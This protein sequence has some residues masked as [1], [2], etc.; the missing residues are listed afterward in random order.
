MTTLVS[1]RST[2]F[3]EWVVSARLLRS[4]FVLIDVGC[5]GGVHSRW[6]PLRPVM[7][8]YGF[9]PLVEEIEALTAR[10]TNP[11]IR[12]AAFAIGDV[13]GDR[14]IYVAVNR[15]QTSFYFDPNPADLK[16][17]RIEAGDATEGLRRVRVRTLDSLLAEG[18]VAKPDYV[19][20]DVEG[21][22]P[23]VIAGG[24]SALGSALMLESESGF[25]AS[26]D[27]P[28]CHFA[29]IS[30]PLHE[31]G[32]RFHSLG[33]WH[34]T[35]AC[36]AGGRLGADGDRLVPAP[37]GRIQGIDALFARDLVADWTQGEAVPPAG[38]ALSDAV[39]KACLL[40]ELFN[41]NDC[42]IE[43]MA[44]ARD[45]PAMAS[46]LLYDPNEAIDLLLPR[47]DGKR[48][49]YAT[50]LE[51][52]AMRARGLEPRWRADPRGRVVVEE[53]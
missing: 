51:F 12:Y 40:F 39:T 53:R 50:Y 35:K 44:H 10:E 20:L 49:D 38:N 42:A 8:A 4:P 14:D 7:H 16:R 2:A 13:D 29:G 22:E 45:T 5:S 11:N 23:K 3:T 47:I 52:F 26:R 27:A 18:A 31:L 46:S 24:R 15:M 43:L 33:H 6:D 34:S 36:M 21:H 19:K 28:E 17:I 32:L 30:R 25:T 37:L 41:L 1:A 48:I 9:D